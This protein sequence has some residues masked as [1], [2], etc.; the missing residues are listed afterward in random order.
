MAK[1]RRVLR[2]TRPPVKTGFDEQF[3]PVLVS[4]FVLAGFLVGTDLAYLKWD[5]TRWYARATTWLIVIPLATGL[6]IWLLSR[7]TSRSIRRGIQL[8][9]VLCLIVH[10]V[11][12]VVSIETDVFG[13][14]W[15]QF[16]DVAR[17]APS[18]RMVLEAEQPI[19]LES[20]DPQRDSRLLRPVASRIPDASRE[21]VAQPKQRIEQRAASAPVTQEPE[22][23]SSVPSHL[24]PRQPPADTSPRASVE[25]SQLS[26]QVATAQPN[27]NE[28]IAQPQVGPP[29]PAESTPREAAQDTLPRSATRWQAD[30]PAVS[31]EMRGAAR[32][33]RLQLSRRADTEVPSPTPA[34]SPSLPRN[35][36]PSQPKPDAPI[37]NNRPPRD[38]EQPTTEHLR[39]TTASATRQPA[40]STSIDRDVRRKVEPLA[41]S[42]PAQIRRPA[43][44]RSQPQA[45]AELLPTNRPLRQAEPKLAANATAAR[46]REQPAPEPQAEP[47]A[48]NAL[49][50]VAAPT[51]RNARLASREPSAPSSTPEVRQPQAD[52]SD[53]KLARQQATSAEGIS[54]AAPAPR[55]T[56]RHTPEARLAASPTKADRPA[57]L[58]TRQGVGPPT[59]EPAPLAFNRAQ[60]GRAGMGRSPNLDR[61]AGAPPSPA[62]VA[63][64]SIE[65]K[66]ATQENPPGPDLTPN[67]VAQIRRSR[68]E[69]PRP[70]TSTKATIERWAARAGSQQPTELSASSSASLLRQSAAA[71]RSTTSAA[72]GQIEVDMG[73]TR[74]VSEANRIRAS[75]GGQPELNF[76]VDA[77][78]PPRRM[79]GGRPAIAVAADLTAPSAVSPPVGGDAAGDASLEP[80]GASLERAA[81]VA[82][83]A[84]T[85]RSTAPPAEPATESDASASRKASPLSNQPRRLAA[86]EEGPLPGTEAES[87]SPNEQLSRA[88]RPLPSFSSRAEPISLEAVAD[89][90]Q[91]GPRDSSPSESPFVAGAAL[92]AD[93]SGLVRQQA[94]LPDRPNDERTGA[95]AAK[96]RIDALADNSSAASVE[97][98]SAFPNSRS[99]LPTGDDSADRPTAPLSRRRIPELSLSTLAEPVTTAVP[100]QGD[101]PEV[102]NLEAGEVVSGLEVGPVLRQRVSALPI[103]IQRPPG[104]G[105]TGAVASLEL[106]LNNRRSQQQSLQIS[107]RAARFIRQEFGGRPDLDTTVLMPAEAFRRRTSRTAPD[108]AS[109]TLPGPGPQTEEAIERGL[110]FLASCQRADGSWSLQ[111][112]EDRATLFSD[113]AATGLALLAF[114]GAGYTHHEHQ[115]AAV[116]KAALD[117]LVENQHDSGDL[118]IALDEESSRAVHLYSHSIAALALCEA[119]GMTQDPELREPAQRAID[120]IVTAQDKTYGG[121]RYTPGRGADTSVSG[122]MMMAL[123]SGDLAGLEI[124]SATY[125]RIRRWLGYAQ[126]SSRQAHLY[127]YNPFAPDTPS[128]RHGRSPTPS[129]TAVGLLMRLYDGWKRDDQAMIQ[130]ATYLQ[131]NPPRLGTITNPQRDTYYWYYAT[132]VMFHMGGEYWEEWNG[133]LRPLLLNSQIRDGE[134]MGSWDP[135]GPVPDRWAPHAGRLYVTTMNLLSLEVYYRHLPLYE[136]TAR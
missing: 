106:G 59:A 33:A 103:D 81:S 54:V 75:G 9:V 2:K 56:P 91:G 63:S 20:P 128:Q 11:L 50:P 31:P 99:P 7:V 136:D 65:R 58:Q 43:I 82:L 5:A 98:R 135:R 52:R 42:S 93:G 117:Y 18:R 88:E 107:P 64:G 108:S 90:G 119:Y 126:A 109:P 15:D 39:P 77:A 68:A 22:I 21:A 129:M 76:E 70:S 100:A 125:E 130:G 30:R 57:I 132:Q 118:Y 13:R 89:S 92:A 62:H 122:W 51:A 85:G 102:A 41:G 29:L 114:Q 24:T 133:Q 19:Q 111:C 74:V 35:V 127:R 110:S 12:F 36:P 96:Q 25:P 67:Q 16:A 134:L 17:I 113:T 38:S 47:T 4:L 60:G 97:R 95:M 46:P 83:S 1:N 32:D 124:N 123:K 61:A 112:L 84:A 28:P 87:V 40:R 101:A 105:G 3:W 45:A 44:A 79:A 120:F 27:L 37:A 94:Q 121:W 8:S 53:P 10:L 66:V 14:F 26:R 78:Q 104:P 69:Q 86:A 49:A 116:V 23:V 34:S 72:R 71:D 48:D 73:P 6:T 55:L 80:A 131:E 115:Y